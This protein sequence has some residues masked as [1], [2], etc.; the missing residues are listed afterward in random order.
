M[1]RRTAAAASLLFGM[2]L[3]IL[4]VAWFFRQTVAPG[5]KKGPLID[6]AS[7][8][9][10]ENAMVLFAFA[11]CVFLDVYV[12]VL[13]AWRR[14]GAPRWAPWAA[15]ALAAG[16]SEAGVRGW[17][18][19]D[20]VTYFRPHPTLHWVVRPNLHDFDNLKG[21]GRIDTN[22]DGMREVTVPREKPDGEYRV[23]VLGDSSNFGHGV[24]GDEVWSS[25][26]GTLVPKVTVLNGA[27][28]GWTT[29][30]AVEFLRETG[31]AYR[32]DMVI[33]G[34]NNDPGPEYISDRDRVPGG[35]V[36]A[37]N[38]LLFR[39]ET[40]LLT[41]EVLLSIVRHGSAQYVKRDAGDEP[42]YGKLSAEESAGLIPRVSLDDF[43]ANLAALD[44]LA[45][46]LVWVNMP[47]NRSEPELVERY[48]NPTYREAA[49]TLAEER[50]FRLVDV[51]MRWLR[52]RE[53]GLFQDGHVFH[54]NAAGHRRMAEQIA[55]EVF[56][57]SQVVSGP[58]P[59]PTEATLRFG[60]SSLTPV[61]AH[62]LAVLRAMPELAEEHGL[63]LALG[64]YASGKTQGDDVA[65]GA[66]D[67]FFTCEVP[68]IQ[69]LEGRTDVR[70]VAAPGSLGRI[71]VVA[72]GVSE[73]AGLRGRKVGLA[74]GST[75]AMDWR[76][77]GASAGADVVEHGTDE[78]FAALEDGR[79]DAAVSWDPWVEDWLR[80][81]PSLK[82]LAER[83]F[84][85]VLAVSVP[86]ST[87][88]AGRGRRLVALVEDALRVAA[89]D[90]P[91]W[92]AAVATLSGWPVEVVRAVA[93]RN[94]ILRDGA[95]SLGWTDADTQ[96]LQRAAAFA[97]A[98]RV[99]GPE[100]V[101][102]E[103]LDG[104]WPAPRV[105]A[106]KG[107]PGK[108]PPGPP[109]PGAKGP[110]PGPG[111]Q[112]PGGLGGPQGP[113]GPGPGGPGGPQGPGG[114]PPGPA[115]A[116]AAPG[117]GAPQGGEPTPRP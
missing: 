53:T 41:R 20:M 26:L 72:R 107:G 117:V 58:P 21:G 68:A 50:G 51:D 19:Y 95:G 11:A 60:I 83:E 16:V 109:P 12:L 104:Q 103:L 49:R 88:E 81:D 9:A 79:I 17:L 22:A 5:W 14:R 37:A 87:Y 33:A 64:D 89:A 52:T 44:E 38:R 25:V 71:A 90:R 100:L 82:V 94:V 66:L 40:Y 30:Q 61:H 102:L 54:P 69:M 8:Y 45:P 84:R 73:I 76:T 113:G 86:W 74:P 116:G 15:L 7:P 62:V 1:T 96:G 92:D 43:R 18:V 42:L 105:A 3:S 39:F 70:A 59:A 112:G 85:S 46:E 36:R 28:P 6:P 55:Q 47:I 97:A 65:K 56:E 98:G 10:P 63:E 13:A 23:L 75:P 29:Y 24:E 67:A 4:A 91:R 34:F 111:G 31:L 110:R 101:G 80:K 48:V 93:D 78:L 108:R 35:A 114:P 99:R 27:T 32:P 106:G 57:P 2:N 115:G 77:W